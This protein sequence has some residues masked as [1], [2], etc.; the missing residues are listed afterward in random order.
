MAPP[1]QHHVHL[2][3]HPLNPDVDLVQGEVGRSV[4][5]VVGVDNTGTALPIGLVRSGCSP[6]DM[7][8]TE[9]SGDS[10]PQG[11]GFLSEQE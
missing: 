2:E 4:R 11:A 10:L 3:L 1:N 6:H 8:N 9:L 7:R 5:L